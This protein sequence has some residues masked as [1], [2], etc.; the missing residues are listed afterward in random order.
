MATVIQL[1]S[2]AATAEGPLSGETGHGLLNLPDV[3]TY[4]IVAG[5]DGG[6]SESVAVRILSEALRIAFR[7]KDGARPAASVE[8]KAR[9]IRNAIR[10][11]GEA[12]SQMPG[13]RRAG[14][15]TVAVLAFDEDDPSRASILNVGNCRCHRFRDG[16]VERLTRNDSA[17]ET[18]TDAPLLMDIMANTIGLDEDV[19]ISEQYVEVRAGDSLVLLPGTMFRAKADPQL[20]RA[21]RRTSH[22]NAAQMAA[23]LVE[24]AAKAEEAATGV[25]LVVRCEAG[26][27]PAASAEE[28]PAAASE[29]IEMPEEAKQDEG[30]IA[31][32]ILAPMPTSAPNAEDTAEDFRADESGEEE[33]EPAAKRSTRKIIVDE[34][35]GAGASVPSAPEPKIAK[36]ALAVSA[37]PKSVP[38]LKPSSSPL[39]RSP[40]LHSEDEPQKNSPW[41][42]FAGILAAAVII[43]GL[44]WLGMHL[45]HRHK[46][47]ANEET[48][49][50]QAV[51]SGDLIA[52]AKISGKWN[53]TEKALAKM[54]TV[55]ADDDATAHAW[56]ALWHQ[57]AGA[58]FSDEAARSRLTVLDMLVAQAGG[59]A[60]PSRPIWTS[61]NRA[62][63]VCSLVSEKQL[64]LSASV[65]QLLKTMNKRSD[66]PF[67]D[68]NTQEATLTGIGL[69]ARSHSV[70]S[71]DS[72]R[73]AFATA[74][75]SE[76][77][78]E[79]WLTRHVA[80]R[81]Q[82]EINLQR[83]PGEPLRQLSSSLDRAWDGLFEVIAGSVADSAY[84]HKH[85][86]AS[87]LPRLNR[88]DAVRQN[89][90]TDRKRYGDV[91]RWRTETQNKQL[92][93]WLLNET[94]SLGA[95]LGKAPAPA[96]VPANRRR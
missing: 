41:P 42:I 84:W 9:L 22:A 24:D 1:S 17:E 82:D 38:S 6:P 49:L 4:A 12:I 58:E 59:K 51:N 50:Q 43:G 74:R 80:D 67:A 30:E 28:I 8:G 27:A 92:L 83:M 69:F 95:Q 21:M 62:D 93:I 39:A 89:V 29:K 76:G 33:E 15:A 10:A 94:G 14:G 44:A 53:D 73:G 88:L 86:P 40:L 11:A 96:V 7:P 25:A 64:Q 26:E 87:L 36:P 75:I 45:W 78:L 52:Q 66:I 48:E 3:C 57:A 54:P 13:E 68:R 90:L 56:I 5:S 70:Q 72:I 23:A 34:S 81:P 16:R 19:N 85:A 20:G 79:S 2:A 35:A 63:I 77:Q 31:D 91:H 65:E 61:E 71:L 37:A 47:H 46:T 55:P 32:E 18:A 60:P